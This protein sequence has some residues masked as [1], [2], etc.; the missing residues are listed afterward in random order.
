MKIYF[1]IIVLFAFTFN[2]SFAQD[3]TIGEKDDKVRTLTDTTSKNTITGKVMLI[4]FD[5]KMYMSEI[6]REIAEEHQLNFNEVRS[7]FRKELNAN[8]F[9]ELNKSNKVISMLSEDTGLTKDLAYI[10]MSIGYKYE[11]LP[12]RETAKEAKTPSEGIQELFAGNKKKEEQG[13]SGIKDGQVVTIPDNN[14]KYMNTVVTNPKMFPYLNEKYE[15]EYYV[16]INQLDIKKA[17]DAD[18]YAIANNDYKREIKVHYTIFDK[19]GNQLSGGAAFAYFPSR[20]NNLSY[21]VNNNFPA[22]AK[23]TCENIPKKPKVEAVTTK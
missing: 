10:Y 14:Q 12:P 17:A 23:Y 9:H 13:T 7:N 2:F 11:L 20:T 19:G 1:G 21:I 22:I 8:L 6:D 4:P 16:F 15:A 18:Q 3:L 5:N